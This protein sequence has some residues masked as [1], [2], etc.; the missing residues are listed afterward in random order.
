MIDKFSIIGLWNERNY[1]IELVDGNL[2]LVGENGSGKTTVLRMLY[3]V[4][5]RNWFQVFEEDFKEIEIGLGNDILK[6]C[7]EDAQGLDDYYIDVKRDFQD[8]LPYGV[9]NEIIRY[10]G[11]VTT[12]E[13]VLEACQILHFPK[14][15]VALI[16]RIIGSKRDILPEKILKANEWII[17][18]NEYPIIYL[19]TYRRSEKYNPQIDYLDSQIRRHRGYELINSYIEVA[20]EGMKDV[21]ET[22]KQKILDIK[23]RV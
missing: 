6:I 20:K 12:P 14:S 10:C 3:N 17:S 18:H 8:A 19:P 22:I 13:K 9:E 5:S 23:L 16:E 1:R 2:I 7:S 15:Y 4:L 11:E 21:D